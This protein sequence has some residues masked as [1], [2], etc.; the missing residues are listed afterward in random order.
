MLKEQHERKSKQKG[1]NL[2]KVG[3]TDSIQF[4]AYGD[5]YKWGFYISIPL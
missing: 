4:E 2:E 1:K 5:N 3:R